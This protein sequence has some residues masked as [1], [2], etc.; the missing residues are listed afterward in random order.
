MP[1]AAAT[2]VTLHSRGAIWIEEIFSRLWPTVV[3]TEQVTYNCKVSV[4]L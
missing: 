2:A 4:V 1:A 3:P